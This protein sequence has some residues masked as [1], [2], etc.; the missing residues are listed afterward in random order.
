[1]AKCNACGTTILFGGVRD[2]D[3]RFCNAK[4]HAKG[5]LIRIARDIPKDVIAQHTASIYHG[6]C[7]KCHGPGPVDVHTSHR[8]WSAVFLTSWR[9]QPHICCR[10]CGR[11]QQIGDAAFSL[12][13]GWWGFPWGLIMTPVQIGRNLVG[14]FG[15]KGEHAPSVDLERIAGMAIASEAV[16]RQPVA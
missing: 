13:L 5:Y 16:K 9:N 1:M 4:C 3:L 6:T 10:S 2:G 14:V 11:K 15:R 8:I 12:V 7:P